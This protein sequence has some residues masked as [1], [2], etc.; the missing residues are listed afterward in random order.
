MLTSRGLR[1][2]PVRRGADGCVRSVRGAGFGQRRGRR[3]SCGVRWLRGGG[4]GGGEALPGKRGPAGSRLGSSGGREGWH[5][6]LLK[7]AHY[8]ELGSYQYWPVL[9]P[10]GIRLLHLRADPR[11][12]KDNPHHRRLPGLPAFQAVYQKVPDWPPPLGAPGGAPAA[13]PPLHPFCLVRLLLSPLFSAPLFPS[14][15]ILFIL[16]APS[17]FVIFLFSSPGT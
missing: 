10:R 4:C 8:I 5:Q 11:V 15:S 12:P 14:C 1:R 6:K 17:F 7:S 3:T 13:P 9:V 2:R 16:F